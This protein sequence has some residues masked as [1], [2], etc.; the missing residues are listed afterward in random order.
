[1]AVCDRSGGR[2]SPA[3]VEV[4]FEKVQVSTGQT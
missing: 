3:P 2:I 1:V 4:T